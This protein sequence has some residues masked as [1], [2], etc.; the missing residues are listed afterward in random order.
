MEFIKKK[1]LEERQ[2]MTG[3]ADPALYRLKVKWKSDKNDETN[4]GYNTD[5]LVKMFSK[6]YYQSIRLIL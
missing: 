5:N 3:K 1:I 4:G 6:V 2:L